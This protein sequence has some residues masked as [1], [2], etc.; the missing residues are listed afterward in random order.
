MSFDVNKPP[1]RIMLK[2]SGEA[3]KGKQD[4]GF[5]IDFVD[6]LS[7][8]IIELTQRGIQCVVIL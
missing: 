1:R 3:L 7:K 2:L 6:G 4:F 8:K 5:D